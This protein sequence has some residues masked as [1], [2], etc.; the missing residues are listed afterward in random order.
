MI[1]KK[2]IAALCLC[3]L[4]AVSLLPTNAEAYFIPGLPTT[5]TDTVPPVPVSDSAIRTKEVGLTVFG[6]TVPGL[7]WDSIAIGI[8]K[9]TIE[10]IVDS[11]TDWINSG[12]EGSPTYVTNP[13]RYFANIADGI[14][15]DFIAGS[16]LGFLCSPFQQ[17]IRLSLRNNYYQRPQT[18]FQCTWTGV[19]GNIEDFYNDF[20]VGGWDGWFQM[21]QNPTNN[22]YD[23]YIKAQIELDGRIAKAVGLKSAEFNVNSGFLSTRDCI[24]RNGQPSGDDYDDGSG[25]GGEGYFDPNYNPAFNPG[26]CLEQGPVKTP[27]KVIESQLEK[28]LG[29]GL[30]QLELADSFDQ[31]INALL[32]QLLNKTVFAAQGI[33]T[34]DKKN[35]NG[36]VGGGTGVVGGGSQTT[37]PQISCS[38]RTQSATAGEDKV[39]WGLQSALEVGTVYSWSGDE[40]S[41]ASTTSVTLVYQTPGTK[42]ASVTAQPPASAGNSNPQPITVSCQN[43]V[44]VSRYRPLTV[45]CSPESYTTKGGEQVKWDAFVSGGSGNIRDVVWSGSE[46]FAPKTHTSVW[47][48]FDPNASFIVNRYF[49]NDGKPRTSTLQTIKNATTT[50]YVLTRIYMDGDGPRDLSVTIVDNDSTVPAVVEKRCDGTIYVSG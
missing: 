10:K 30:T 4:L 39:T 42:T 50:K 44:L 22:P 26:A 17:E 27:G 1:Y 7:S 40:M 32:G 34:N 49:D 3:S 19:K 6:Y 20:S 41:A 38:A 28:T 15:G 37:A 9:K 45:S 33:F 23:T 43:S 21:T 18:Q 11:T 5:P 2:Y 46:N 35:D 48:Q 25:N 13:E 31:L 47:P 24:R 16:E 12:F 8:A 14:A 36:K 29:T